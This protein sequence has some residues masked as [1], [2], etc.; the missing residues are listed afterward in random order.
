MTGPGTKLGARV[1]WVVFAA[2][3]GTML[4]LAAWSSDSVA[5]TV[6]YGVYGVALLAAS[7]LIAWPLWPDWPRWVSRF[8]VRAHRRHTPGGHGADGVSL[9][10]RRCDAVVLPVVLSVSLLRLL[11]SARLHVMDRCRLTSDDGG[12][13]AAAPAGREPS[14]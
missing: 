10:C 6:A 12:S 3:T 5:L 1:P 7:V 4:G 2:T 11:I 14:R 8:E 9:R 13:P